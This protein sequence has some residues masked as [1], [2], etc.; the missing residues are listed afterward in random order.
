[1][2]L[3]ELKKYLGIFILGV[4]L[5]AVYKTFDNFGHV[6]SWGQH[7]LSLLTPFVIGFCIAYVLYIPC[8]KIE[9]LCQKTRVAFVV[10]RRRG[11]AVASI[12]LIFLAAV[13]L[14]LVSIIP[15]LVKSI[16][17]FVDQLPSIIQGAVNWFNSLGIYN[18][19][20]VTIQKLL[21]NDLISIDKILGG[22]SFDNMN[23][24]AKGVMSFGTGVFNA[25]MGIIISVY[26]LIDRQS[27]KQTFRRFVRSYISEKHREF[28]GRYLKKINQFINLYIYCQLVDAL[29]IFILSFLTLTIMRVKYAPLLALMVGAFNL[30]PYFGAITA[31]VLAAVITVFTKSFT[32]GI[33]VA[34]VLI[35]L[36]QL[37]AN[38]IQ[39]KLLSGS[40]NVKPFWVILGIITGGGL[41]GVLGIFLAV[42][43]FA[44][45]RIILIDVLEMRERKKLFKE[46]LARGEPF[47]ENYDPD[48]AACRIQSDLNL[49]GQKPDSR[50]KKK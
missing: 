31:T 30:I 37:D 19:N 6:V 23:K 48:T 46:A 15:A 40:L 2:W 34:V 12:Y 49:D 39:P 38:F 10:K 27:L 26:I 3:K 20:D 25:F 28:F 9:E 11:I 7:L 41:F 44:L 18:I 43:I 36:Q 47:D 5:I 33:I 35:V 50:K 16:T 45:L 17:E 4:A 21:S 14:L 22:F 42:P 1:M 13:S 29:I 8:R 24:Y 32:S